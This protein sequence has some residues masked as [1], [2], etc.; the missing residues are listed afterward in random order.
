MRL[1]KLFGKTLREVPAEAETVSHQLLLKSGMIHQVAAGVYSY[2]PLAWRVLR[3]IER[4]IREEMDAAGGQ[5]LSMPVLQP[6]E[7]W[8]ESG[9]DLAFGKG[10]FTLLDRRERKLVLAPTH[11]ELITDLARRN[12]Q[13]YR[14]LP[15][16][17]YQ[18]QTKFR[19]EPRPRGGLVRVREFTMKDLYSFDVDEVALDI[20]YQRMLQAYKNVYARCGLDT[21]VVEADS[22]AIGGKDSHEFM[23][24]AE[25]GED[26]IIYC[27]GC[28]WSA[29]VEKATFAK[30][31]LECEQLL[32]LEEVATPGAKT[33]EEV[34]RFL[35]VPK[36]RT[37]KAVF[38][39]VDG[40]LVFV[41]IR[42][43]IEVNEVKLKNAL[44]CSD[45]RLANDEEGQEAGLVAGSASAAGLSGI[46]VVADDSIT[47]GQN[48]VVGANKADVHLKNAN[49]PRDFKVDLM[50]DIAQAVAGYQCIK[51]GGDLLSTRGIEVGHVFKLGTAFSEKQ[52]ALYLDR[53]GNQK[54]LV[55][56]CYGI[57][58]GRLL[59]AAIEQNHDEKGIIWPV[60]IAPYHVYLCALGGEEGEIVSAAEALYAE[61]KE[62][63]F[64]VLFDDRTESAGVKFNDADLLG[65]PARI[66]VSRRTLKSNS[67][68]VKL[69]SEKDAELVKLG[70]VANRLAIL[71]Q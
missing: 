2:L 26:E 24:I 68:E 12:V 18:I 45:L 46:K 6:F 15:R 17:L 41:T 22:G 55:M 59:A 1:T 63:K 40:E 5:E 48:F 57:G 70:E 13:S 14:D 31:S 25:S 35:G 9:R 21:V 3:K 30:T 39:S 71:L 20:S 64:E 49:Y 66:V 58:I 16:M 56:G 60:P 65:M 50:I 42:G 36:E 38:Y 29:N 51:C 4:I 47:L 11:E 34:A 8:E 61:L 19:D 53:D 33:I 62:R 69:R 23:V 43:D 44:K 7:I 37:L 52:G 28:G 32:S 27:N 67:A 10:L 54:P